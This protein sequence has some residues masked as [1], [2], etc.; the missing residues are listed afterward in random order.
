[1]TERGGIVVRRKPPFALIAV[2]IVAAAIGAGW[3]IGKYRNSSPS[4]LPPPSA[5]AKTEG[6]GELLYQMHCASCHGS[7]GGGDGTAAATLRPPPRDFGARPWRFGPSKESIRRVTLDGIPGTAMPASRTALTAADAD[8]LTDY[9]FHLA[10]SRPQI[11]YEPS[12]E[13]LLLRE[14]GFVDL[15]GTTPPQLVVTDSKGKTDKLSDFKGRLVLIHFWGTGCTHCLKEIPHLKMLESEWAGRPV[16]I[17][18]VCADAEDAKEAQSVL[19]RAT[20][21]V[22]AVVD[23]SGIGLA[24]YEVKVLPTVWLIDKAGKVIGRAHGA[25][26]WTSPALKRVLENWLP[27]AAQRNGESKP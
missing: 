23:E 5:I 24:R 26:D 18:N 14:A 11:V 7:E 1:M 15:R 13:E 25:K 3:A 16:T 6:R 17:L 27:A 2:A 10:T 20:P 9:V 21:G 8:L 22:R 19:D 4:S 12:P